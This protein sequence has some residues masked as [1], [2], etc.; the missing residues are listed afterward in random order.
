MDESS[1]KDKRIGKVGPSKLHE[2]YDHEMCYSTTRS[3]NQI[4]QLDHSLRQEMP[5]SLRILSLE[6]E[7]RLGTLF[8]EEEFISL[9]MVVIEHDQ[10]SIPIIA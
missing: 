10:A 7:I 6:G 9:P 3:H 1:S 5:N 8:F 2:C 4:P